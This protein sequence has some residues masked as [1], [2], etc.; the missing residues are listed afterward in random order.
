MACRSKAVQRTRCKPPAPWK[1]ALQGGVCCCYE[2]T[3]PLGTT[4]Q[5]DL[6]D[7]KGRGVIATKQFSRGEF[8]VEYHGDLIE[9]TDAKEREALYAQDPSTGCYMYYFQYLSKTYW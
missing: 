5:I 6:I 2:P 4:Q 9:I 1:P 8:V 3:L 7:G